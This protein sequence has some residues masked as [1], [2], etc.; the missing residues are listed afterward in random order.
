M[1][2]TPLESPLESR[3]VKQFEDGKSSNRRLFVMKSSEMVVKS[4]EMVVKSSEM[5]VK[6]L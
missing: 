2:P 4:S 1:K 6:W 5:V 3:K